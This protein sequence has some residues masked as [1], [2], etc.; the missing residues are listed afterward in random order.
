M[1]IRAV[2]LG[3]LCFGISA[4]SAVVTIVS[5]DP[6]PGPVTALTQI[7]VT[8]SAPVTG[9]N[10]DDLLLNTQ[11][12]ATVSGGGATYTFSFDQPLYGNVSITWFE[13][14]GI[15]DLA[16][17]P[18]PF[19]A[20]APGS[21]WMYDLQDT[22]PPTV[23]GLFPPAGAAVPSLGQVEVTFSEEVTGVDAADLL[24]NG[25]PAN[26]VL[27]LPAGP[28]IFKFSTPAPGTVQMQWAAG[29]G[30]TDQ[31]ESPNAFG[32]GPWT[33]LYDP[34]LPI[35]DLLINEILASNQ[36]GLT[37]E[38]G[39]QE[40]WI[41]IYN[42]GTNTVNL[43]G[44]SLSDDPE[45]PS[46]WVFGSR[47]LGPGQYLV[48]FASGKD[49]PNPTA[50]N[51]F[52]TNF[53][54]AGDGE[55]LGLYTPD[56]PRVLASALNPKFPEQRNDYAYGRDTNGNLRYFATPTP[57]APNGDSSIVA[58]AAPVRF[59]VERGCY[60]N[61]FDLYLSSET[62]GAQ[63]RYTVDGSEPTLATGI[64]YGSALPITKTT[65]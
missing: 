41:E 20:H 58:L 63:I 25:Q 17:P 26:S 51:R 53:Q 37:D 60:S 50:S 10:A 2:S 64:P 14:H 56:S 21:T 40:D 18:N 31:A 28:Y 30:I 48:V 65:I 55:F 62:P 8:F 13:P 12:A 29:H 57:G 59:S 6:P 22:V 32:G 24:I 23:T 33:Y 4:Y 46:L 47:A 11:P 42:R 16:M 5:V 7:V 61:A 1:F 36:T 52:H 3:V 35:G 38:D 49:R 43:N 27:R 15:T 39:Q 19:D 34:N 45:I 44:W 9:V 54:L